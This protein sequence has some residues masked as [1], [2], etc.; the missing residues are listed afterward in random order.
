[1]AFLTYFYIASKPQ[2]NM[3]KICK[4]LILFR[5]TDKLLECI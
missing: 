5:E 1:L 3:Q 2:F 4:S